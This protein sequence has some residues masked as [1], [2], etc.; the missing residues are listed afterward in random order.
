[1]C[2]HTHTC[3]YTTIHKPH[4]NRTVPQLL[5]S[6]PN[7]LHTQGTRP[8]TK[9]SHGH[10]HAVTPKPPVARTHARTGSSSTL[11][12]TPP[13]PGV[14]QIAWQR[15]QKLHP[16][17]R[18]QA[19]PGRCPA[20]SA[21]QRPAGGWVQAQTPQGGARRQ[22]PACRR[23]GTV[24]SGD[25]CCRLLPRQTSRALQVSE[26]ATPRRP[27]AP[28]TSAGVA[29]GPPSLTRLPVCLPASRIQPR[30]LPT[31][32]ARGRPEG[33]SRRPVAPAEARR[34]PGDAERR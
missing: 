32:D 26:E 7:K 16:A 13:G 5:H 30:R 9:H 21:P 11:S 10:G 34:A 1:M 12:T 24:V 33:R 18:V 6:Q 8:Y 31:R 14:R 23:W 4:T 17:P 20:G 28:W 27:T 2:S 3:S 22:G 29:G 19:A 15:A 25:T